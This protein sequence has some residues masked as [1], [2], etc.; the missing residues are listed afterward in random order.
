MHLAPNANGILRKLG[1]FAEDFGANLMEQVSTF[2]PEMRKEKAH[3]TQLT[4][5]KSTGELTRSFPLNKANSIW[6]HSWLLA[7]RVH[8]HDALKLAA[9]RIEGKGLPAKLH[10]GNKTVDVDVSKATITL[11]DG[12]T[13][14]GDLILGADGVKSITRTKVAG[15]EVTPFGSG[16]SAFRFLIRRKAAQ[17][18]PITSKFVQKSGELIIW[19]GADRRVV[20]YPTTNN[21]LLNFVCIHP[22]S[23]TDAGNDTWNGAGNYDKMLKVYEGFDPALLALLGKADRDSLKVWKLLDMETLSSW[24]SK[25]R[26]M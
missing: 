11:E 2:E 18:D 4:E 15:R 23:E 9:T 13:V 5:Y 26:I 3:R 22:E 6:Q 20:M 7:H 1:I 19:F 24:V 14:Q 16:K 25:I 8:L 10:L 12:T 21:E 17:D